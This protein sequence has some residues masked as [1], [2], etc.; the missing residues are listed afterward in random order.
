M[1]EDIEQGRKEQEEEE[2]EGQSKSKV[3]SK[4]ILIYIKVVREEKFRKVVG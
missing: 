2:R 3:Y 4:F 1:I